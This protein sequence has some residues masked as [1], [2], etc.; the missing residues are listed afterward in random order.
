[1]ANEWATQSEQM[2]QNNTPRPRRTLGYWLR[3]AIFFV[4]TLYLG[5]SLAIGLRIAYGT[6]HPARSGPCCLTPT[7]YA[8]LSY[9]SVTF[10]SRDGLRIAGW[11]LSSKNG[12]AVV[13][14]HGHSSHRAMTLPVAAMLAEEGYGVLMIDLRAHGESE[15]QTF[16]LWQ[17]GDDVLGAVDYLQTRPDVDPNRIGAWGF[18]AGAAASVHAAAQSKAIQGVIADGL[19]WTRFK[20]ALGLY[21]GPT[22]PYFLIDWVQMTATDLFY[23]GG[24]HPRALVDDVR[25]IPPRPLLI[26]VAED[27]PFDNERLASEQYKK[28]GGETV[29]VWIVPGATHGGGWDLHPDKYRRHLLGFFAQALGKD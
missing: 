12:A 1:M 11:Y 2:E 27:H 20:D 5:V 15:G 26:V 19:Q 24:S 23:A 7:E 13:L 22:Y 16:T 9:E 18:S 17:A 21:R 8:G 10:A 28:I 3:L 25:Q 29:S 4:V 6:A 14:S